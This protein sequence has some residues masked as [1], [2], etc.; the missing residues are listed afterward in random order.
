METGHKLMAHWQKS[1]IEKV[2][3]CEFCSENSMS[4]LINSTCGLVLRVFC[5][6]IGMIGNIHV[7][8]ITI[9]NQNFANSS[10]GL[11]T[12]LTAHAT[13]DSIQ[14]TYILC[15]EYSL[16][17]ITNSCNCSKPCFYMPEHGKLFVNYVMNNLLLFI[18]FL[19]P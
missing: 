9:C 4:D 3:F 7:R 12:H 1:L 15:V 18:I 19:A 6:S 8:I 10:I 5:Y 13:R 17:Q 14:N 11:D 16:V 2:T